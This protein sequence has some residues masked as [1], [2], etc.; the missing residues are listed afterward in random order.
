MLPLSQNLARV[1]G[2]LDMEPMQCRDPIKLAATGVQATEPA[3]CH[4]FLRS[5]PRLRIRVKQK[6]AHAS[7]S[8]SRDNGCSPRALPPRHSTD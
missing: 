8:A 2:L 4:K 1:E 7:T 3:I 5:V 6:V